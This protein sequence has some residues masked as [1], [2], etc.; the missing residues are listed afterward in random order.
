M[1][2]IEIQVLQSDELHIWK[3]LRLEALADAPYRGLSKPAGFN[4]C[5]PIRIFKWKQWRSAYRDEPAHKT[6]QP[7]IGA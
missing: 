5:G 6:L 2:V 4:L 7:P 1:P 3:K